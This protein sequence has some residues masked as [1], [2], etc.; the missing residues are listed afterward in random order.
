[1]SDRPHRP[2]AELRAFA[3]T[4]L[5]YEIRM[6]GALPAAIVQRNA[7]TVGDGGDA[8]S[9]ALLESFAVHARSLIDF[10][11]RQQPQ[12]PDDA[13]ARDYFY[14]DR[15]AWPLPP[16]TPHLARVKPRVNKEI[17]HLTYGRML[18]SEEA[19]QW[20]FEKI[21]NDLAAVLGN[22]VRAVSDHRVGSDFKTRA[23]EALPYDARY[24]SYFKLRE[25]VDAPLRLDPGGDRPPGGTPTQGLG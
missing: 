15:G 21:A 23:L 22:F 19:R 6:V 16:L 5:L 10:F 25:Q 17:A 9:N 18:V 14:E 2:D 1:M 3:D 11:F 20:Q 13:L 12:F 8:V 24:D 4:H 7:M